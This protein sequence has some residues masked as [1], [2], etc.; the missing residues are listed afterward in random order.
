[1]CKD[2]GND[3]PEMLFVLKMDDHKMT[4]IVAAVNLAV[5][6]AIETETESEQMLQDEVISHCRQ[7]LR[8]TLERYKEYAGL[9]WL[10]QFTI[11][12]TKALTAGREQLDAM[13]LAERLATLKHNT[14]PHLN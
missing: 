4:C 1:M 6:M 9:H 2:C 5:A 11:E 13:S 7:T 10:Q 12:E 8:E 3:H 14:N